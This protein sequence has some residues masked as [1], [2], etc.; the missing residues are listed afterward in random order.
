MVEIYDMKGKNRKSDE[1][2]GR[3]GVKMMFKRKQRKEENVY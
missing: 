1:V 2:T 3:M